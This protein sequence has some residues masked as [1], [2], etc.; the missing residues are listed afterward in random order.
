MKIQG[1]TMGFG[2]SCVMSHEALKLIGKEKELK[3]PDV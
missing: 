3:F 2:K 1:F